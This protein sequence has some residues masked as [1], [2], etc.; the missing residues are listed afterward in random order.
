MKTIILFL[1]LIGFSLSVFAEKNISRIPGKAT[2]HQSIAMI[3]NYNANNSSTSLLFPAKKIKISETMCYAWQT[4]CGT[5]HSYC[6][7]GCKLSDKQI[8]SIYDYLE[9]T[10]C[11]RPTNVKPTDTVA[12]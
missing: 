11:S 10:Y 4:S 1:T 9:D 8:L 5:R 7:Q 2:D 12:N 3:N 6:C